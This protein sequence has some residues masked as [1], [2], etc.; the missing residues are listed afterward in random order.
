MTEKSFVS[1]HKIPERDASVQKMMNNIK[2]P[3]LNKIEQA[4][5]N[6]LKNK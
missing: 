1:T 6:F 5:S 2:T 3:F 4:K